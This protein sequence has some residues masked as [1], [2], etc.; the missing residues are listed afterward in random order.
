MVN[1]GWSWSMLDRESPDGR[2]IRAVGAGREAPSERLHTAVVD[3]AS[4]GQSDARDVGS[5]SRPETGPIVA[6]LA[7]PE[8]IPCFR[9]RP[10]GSPASSSALHDEGEC[11]V[12]V[13]HHYVDHR[14]YAE[15]PLR[16]ADLAGPVTGQIELAV[17][18]DWGP[19]RIYDIGV[20]TDRRIVYER[21]LREASSTEEL[22]RYLEADALVDAW[23]HLF[24]PQR[25]RAMWERRFPELVRAA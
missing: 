7:A 5:P 6:L 13:S 15:P 20:E 10:P 1:R 2:R 12:S 8:Q 11:N 21:V 24:L 22:C 23:G 18:I 4:A 14:P 3:C 19:R 25:V 9:R 16:L 17:T